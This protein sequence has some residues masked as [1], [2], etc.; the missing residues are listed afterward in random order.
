MNQEWV[1]IANLVKRLSPIE[2]RYQSNVHC[3]A[4]F[5]TASSRRKSQN[6]YCAIDLARDEQCLGACLISKIDLTRRKP[7]L[8]SCI[9]SR[10]KCISEA[11]NFLK[12]NVSDGANS[13]VEQSVLWSNELTYLL[14]DSPSKT[15]S[16][17]GRLNL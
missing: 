1:Y 4:F 3:V 10:Y 12:I 5:S 16:S 15:G 6:F 7:S 2:L 17:V 11:S 9:N 14:G 13:L 8:Q